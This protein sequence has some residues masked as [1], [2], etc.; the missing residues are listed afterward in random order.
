MGRQI[1]ILASNHDVIN[2]MKRVQQAG[3][4][5]YQI[6]HDAQIIQPF[7]LQRN[8]FNFVADESI[9]PPA[10]APSSEIV[11]V[12][13]DLAVQICNSMA[14][15][16]NGIIFCSVGT[17][18][19]YQSTSYLSSDRTQILKAPE[20]LG[21]LYQAII[22]EIKKTAVIYKKGR[23]NVYSLPEAERMIN[24]H[25]KM[26]QEGIPWNDKFVFPKWFDTWVKK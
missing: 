2:I 24:E 25:L 22:K 5:F 14:T 4:P 9:I 26:R 21:K 19:V 17:G 6:N 1:Q 18:R 12:V 20:S 15:D 11:N 8:E 7:S 23:D 16:S 10:N 3:V 13:Y